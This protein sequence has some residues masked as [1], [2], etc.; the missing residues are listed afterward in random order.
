LTTRR[1]ITILLTLLALGAEVASYGADFPDSSRDQKHSAPDTQADQE[2]T[3]ATGQTGHDTR[4]T[5]CLSPNFLLGSGVLT[6]K[7]ADASG[8]SRRPAL[9]NPAASTWQPP[10]RWRRLLCR[11][12]T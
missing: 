3:A 6:R 10:G 9:D 7:H 4:W 11:D 1:I 8:L 12:L 5:P 2:I